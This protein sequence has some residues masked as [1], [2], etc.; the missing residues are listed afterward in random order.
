[1]ICFDFLL[2]IVFLLVASVGIALLAVG[3]LFFVFFD[4]HGQTVAV[5]PGF[6]ALVDIFFAEHSEAAGFSGSGVCFLT[7]DAE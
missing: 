6:I 3:G 5:Q 7:P 2:E 1:M 4:V